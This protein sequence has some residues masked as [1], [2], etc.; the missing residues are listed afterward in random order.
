MTSNNLASNILGHR[1]G[2]L[3]NDLLEIL[4]NMDNFEESLN[5]CA[6]SPYIDMENI[7]SYLT[8]FQ[9]KFSVLDLN[10]QSLN[11]KFDVLVT[12][13][14]ELASNDFHFSAICLQETWVSNRTDILNTFEIPN[15]IAVHLPATCT[16]HGGLVIYL[17]NSYQFKRLDIYTASPVWEGLFLEIYGGGLKRKLYL[18]NIYRPPR[19]RNSDIKDFI[20]SFT[21]ILERITHPSSDSIIAGDFNIDLLKVDSR[22]L[23]SEYLEL[24]YS[25]SFI[26]TLTLPTRLSRRR[27]TLID[28]I[29]YNSRG[30]DPINGGII[31]NNI[32]DHFMCFICIDKNPTPAKPPKTVQFQ[33]S[34]EHSINKFIAAVNNTDFLSKIN[35]DPDFNPNETYGV[36]SSCISDCLD[37]HLPYKSVKFRKYRHKLNPWITQG[38]LKSLKTRDS[39]YR[40]L[41]SI[42]PNSPQYDV[43]KTNLKTYNNIITKTMRNAK[44]IYYKNMFDKH[45]QDYKKSWKLINSLISTARKKD[46]FSKLFLVNGATV[47]NE[48]AIANHFNDFFASIGLLQASKV[49]HSDPNAYV[50]YLRNPPRCNFTF[51]LVNQNDVLAIISKFKPKTSSGFD[52]ISMKLL[53]RIAPVLSHPLSIA[54]NQSFSTGIFPDLLKLA[55]VFPLYKKDDATL[56]TNYRPISLLPVLSKVFEKIVHK[57]IYTYFNSNSLFCSHQHGFRP[58]HSTETATLEYVDKLL[59]LLDDDKIPFSIFMDLSKAFDTLDHNILL[60]KLSFYGVVDNSFKWFESYLSNRTQ[61]V[62]FHGSTSSNLNLST[63]VPQGSI[64]GPLLFLIYINDLNGVSPF[65]EFLFYADDTTVTSTACSFLPDDTYSINSELDK[66]FQWLCSNKLS[67][68]V[69]KTK[70]MVFHPSPRKR[71]SP[72]LVNLKING[73]PLQNTNEFN[74]LGTLISSN[75]SWNNHVTH[76]CKKLSRAIGI[77]KRLRNM[78]P[79]YVLLSIYHSLFAP[80]LYQSVLVWGHNPG[81]VFKLQK[82]AIRLVFKT[83]YNAHTDNL[84]KVNC[85]PKFPDIYKIAALKFYH[86]YCNNKTPTYFQGI[87]SPLYGPHSHNTRN[88]PPRPQVSKKTYTSKCIRYIIPKIVSIT[89]SNITDKFKSHSLEGFGYYVKR[90]CC[91]QYN[92]VCNIFNCY[93]CGN[94]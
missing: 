3:N 87:F 5:C 36:I 93:I 20:T 74:F 63:G 2:R 73:I 33:V 46:D 94:G 66:I 60:H 84:F 4:R 62:D 67:L 6:E 89:P 43:L 39:L 83:K 68:N 48:S 21:T 44:F 24:L 10:I 77:L 8:R 35:V 69:N 58:L 32:S 90:F 56:L 75:L 91:D 19:D 31:I 80:Y 71:L 85:I 7:T 28:H 45:R 23:Y 34:D 16:S 11:A 9:N 76:I 54:I 38:I 92:D 78:L 29:F 51:N 82:K 52:K 25:F 1:G 37:A 15:Y 50:R 49:P 70:Y 65:F 57:Q 18:S 30:S 72:L 42:C 41:K 22:S 17:H 79:S 47:T 81:R 13:L 88:N 61:Y 14:E 26:P 40:D 86:K 12:F 64:L 59:K 53:K 27:G 55:K